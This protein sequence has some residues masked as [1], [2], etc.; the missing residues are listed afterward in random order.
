MI[1]LLLF[2]IQYCISTLVYHV[3]LV[4]VDSDSDFMSAK[5]SSRKKVDTKVPPQ[6]INSDVQILVCIS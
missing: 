2:S 6:V 3:V 5:K 1:A 4:F